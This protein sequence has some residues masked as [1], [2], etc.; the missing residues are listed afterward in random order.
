MNATCIWYYSEYE[1]EAVNI[2]G[3]FLKYLPQLTYENMEAAFEESK[4][5]TS[6]EAYKR[7]INKKSL[8]SLA[9]QVR[10]NY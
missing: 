5:I 2:F 9:F 10:K 4:N 7:A 3:P 1:E 8:R 6:N